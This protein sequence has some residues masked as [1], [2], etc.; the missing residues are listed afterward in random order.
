MHRI[1]NLIVAG[2]II[3]TGLAHAQQVG[4]PIDL[5]DQYRAGDDFMGI[6]LLGALELKGN[7]L[8]SELSGLAW[9]EDE[10]ILIGVTD[11]GFLLHLKPEIRDGLLTGMELLRHFPLRNREGKRLSKLDSDAEGLVVIGG[12][13]GRSGDSRLIISFE[14]RNRIVRFTPEGILEAELPLPAPLRARRFYSEPNKGLEAVAMHPSLGL[15]TGPEISK[16]SGPIP[17]FGAE[18]RRWYYQPFELDGAM[19]ALETAPDGDGVLLLERAY[20]FPFAPWVIT[21]S[22]IHPE[23]DNGGSLLTA[24]QLLRFVSNQG[25]RIQNFEG[26]T[27]HRNNRYFMVSDDGGLVYLQTQLLYFEI[28]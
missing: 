12:N 17:I 7:N 18:G 23:V 4:Y 9:D 15:L 1:K 19:V 11:R 21:L 25:W 20:S 8:L 14:T 24:Q 6:R 3:F 10:G 22:R 5:S 13:N 2:L 16:R 26:L 27:H 28:Q